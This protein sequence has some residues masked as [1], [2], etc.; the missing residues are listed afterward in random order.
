MKKL[1]LTI[2]L[3]IPLATF[4]VN[5]DQ[6][7]MKN[8]MLSDLATVRQAFD[9]Q[10]APMEWKQ[11]YA[12]WNLEE[13][14]ELA[15]FKILSK[16][17]ITVKDYQQVLKEFFHSTRDYH[18]GVY[19]Y[20]TEAA[21]LPFAIVGAENR[22]FVRWVDY[23]CPIPLNEGDEIVSYKGVPMHDLI[24]EIKLREL[25]NPESLTDQAFAEYYFSL[26]IGALGH[27]IP[28]G[29]VTIGVIH[30][31]SKEEVIY[32]IEW[33]YI[34]DIYVGGPF[35]DNFDASYL[36]QE[37]PRL[38]F[39]KPSKNMKAPLYELFLKMPHLMNKESSDA[40]LIGRKD[41]FFPLLGKTTWKAPM[42]SPF[43]AYTFKAL[44]KRIGFIRIPSFDGN[45]DLC[46]QFGTLVNQLEKSTD[47]LIVDV[48][49]NPG[50]SVTY[51]YALASMLTSQSLE[52]PKERM[53]I[54]YNDLELANEFVNDDY[55]NAQEIE[56]SLE[57]ML[58]SLYLGNMHEP[59]KAYYLFLLSEWQEGRHLSNPVYLDGISHLY[60]HRLA[61]YSKPI[62]VLANELSISCADFFPAI[63]QDNKRGLVFGTRTAGAGGIVLTA[64]HTNLFGVEAYTLTGSIAVRP[65]GNPLENL[66]VSPDIYYEMKAA[67]IQN[68]YDGYRKAV[69][70]A[71][72]KVVK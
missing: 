44:N 26:R 36:V 53:I 2:G 69:L 68:N 51:M 19:F 10:Y 15:K 45:D 16:N 13:Q 5:N 42:H 35:K 57:I 20:S 17:N 43:Q 3:F 12:D 70:E 32:P 6:L 30:K 67:D 31:G 63:I 22:Y 41:S 46:Q 25:G 47:A 9:T 40:I 54:T 4:A 28:K 55:G 49:N 65:D 18:V 21:S 23:S 11:V 52:L 1:L 8:K 33:N 59:M 14:M 27:K 72:K 64:S 66:G 34:P 58:G 7:L 50:G 29:E 60:P 38:P 37:D 48:T 71:L 56:R 61:H 39:I 24:T 62:L